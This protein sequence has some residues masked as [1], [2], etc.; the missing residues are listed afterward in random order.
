MSPSEQPHRSPGVELAV[1]HGIKDKHLMDTT[2]PV[3]IFMAPKAISDLLV[4]PCS[5]VQLGL[6]LE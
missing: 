1:A 4:G 6:F 5:T 3:T 2:P